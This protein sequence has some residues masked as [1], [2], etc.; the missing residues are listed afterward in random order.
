VRVD[1]VNARMH[2]VVRVCV[3]RAFVACCVLFVFMAVAGTV[4]SFVSVFSRLVPS[5]LY[6][7]ISLTI[8][9]DHTP[10]HAKLPDAF[11]DCI[12]YAD[13]MWYGS[14]MPPSFNAKL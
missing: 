1:H 7:R 3:M 9:Q 5:S 11:G 8:L 13:P 12:P 10:S 6:N 14:S 2:C 4:T